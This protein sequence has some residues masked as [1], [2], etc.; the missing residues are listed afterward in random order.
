MPTRLNLPSVLPG[1]RENKVPVAYKNLF[2]EVFRHPL[3]NSNP[4]FET[5]TF[6]L[7]LQTSI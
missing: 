3:T 5:F 2:N 7:L 1:S 6:V 4:N